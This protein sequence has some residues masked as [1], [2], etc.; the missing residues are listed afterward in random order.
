MADFLSRYVF[1]LGSVSLLCLIAERLRPWRE[2]QP[3]LRPQ[4]GQ[5]VFWL[6]F[7]GYFSDFALVYLFSLAH[8]GLDAAFRVIVGHT[9]DTLA[10]LAPAS[11]WLQIPVLLLLSD[12]IEWI[13]HNALHRSPWLWRFHRVHH[14]ILV[15]DWIGNFRFHWF[16]TIVYKLVKYLPLAMLGARWEAVLVVAVI[17]TTIGHLNHSNLNI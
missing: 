4:F 1:W 8:G 7:N 9:P 16:E 12:F 10:L 6:C 13:V 17:S 11:L 3:L 14:S 15:M 2:E 5:D